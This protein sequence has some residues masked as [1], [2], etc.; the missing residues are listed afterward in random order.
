MTSLEFQAEFD[1]SSSVGLA[2]KPNHIPAKPPVPGVPGEVETE[3]G[4]PLPG[5]TFASPCPAQ[6]PELIP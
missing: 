1:L 2:P 6:S 5:A 4:R 3:P